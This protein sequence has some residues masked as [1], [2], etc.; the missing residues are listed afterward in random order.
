VQSGTVRTDRICPDGPICGACANRPTITIL[1]LTPGTR[2]GPYVVT[3]Q[4]GAG[5]MGE[6]YRATDT[7]L[8]RSVAIKVLPAAVAADAARLARFQREA[9]VLAAMNHPHIAAIYGF[10]RSDGTTALVMELVEGPTLADRIEKG[11]TPLDEALPIARQIAEALEAAHEQ[12]IIHRDLKP[13]NIKVRNDGTVKVLDFGLAKAMESTGAMSASVSM[14]PTITTPAMTQAGVILGTA[15]YMSPEQARGKAVDK[16]ADIWA[17]GVVVYELLTGERLFKGQNTAEILAAVIRDEPRLDRVPA[18]MRPLLLRCLEKDSSKRLRD[19]GDIGLLLD[20]QVQSALPRR[21]P[22]LW[23]AA[24]ALLLAIASGLTIL[25]FSQTPP[26]QQSLRFQIPPPGSSVAQMFALSPDGKYLAFVSSDDGP[27]RLWVR[28]MDALDA[29]ALPGTDGATYPFWSPDAQYLGFFAE[30]KLQ[31]IAI[32]GGPSQTLCQATSGRGATWNRDGVILFSAGPTTP[33]FRVS[34]GGGVPTPVT[35]LA[36]DGP[37][38]HRFPSFMPDGRHFFYNSEA[39][40]SSAA[41]L[42]VGSLDRMAPVRLLS[43]QTQALY[44]PPTVPR[45]SGFLVFRRE[46]TLM[47]QPFD[48]SSLRTTGETLPIAEQVATGANNDFG[49]FSI[50]ANGALAYRTGG[51]EANR[52][53]VWVDR[54]GKRLGTATKTTAIDNRFSLS[55]DETTLVMRIDTASRADLWLQDLGRNVLTRFTFRAG[56][57]TNPNWSPDSNDVAFALV[58]PGGFSTDIYKKAAGGGAEELLL[59]AGINGYPTDWSSDGKFIVYQQTD[60]KTGDDLW[61]LPLGGDHRPVLYL[62]TAFNEADAHFSPDPQ[63]SPRWMAYQSDE[64]GRDQIYIQAVPATGAKYQIST[65]GGTNPRWRQDGHEL[66][67][68]SGDRKLMAVGVALGARPRI[69]TPQELFTN[70]G[71][72][73][74]VSSRDGQRF[75]VNQPA[76]KEVTTAAPITVVM[77]W[78]AGNR[79]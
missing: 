31:K 39:D 42:F 4:I 64:S 63:D 60:A 35:T 13:A 8:K 54:T 79:K 66:Y 1:A 23:P 27:S 10:E 49:A 14:S 44:A 40:T 45:G 77:N 20:G 50:A 67:Y 15:A 25:Y 48:A 3:A 16:R 2:L 56:M 12:G 34:S 70:A 73:Y 19:L 22:W 5:G 55:P 43:D 7:N 37:E 47:A 46:G 78:Q 17:F 58:R 11:A 38:G 72:T 24:A 51:T 36:S 52:E 6:V 59:H 9:E 21:A 74:F 18:R 61:L 75:L 65:G 71:M 29:R 53:L 28:A 33:I 32:A 26:V 62:Q 68:M 41:G 76:R 69:G 57:N 30:A